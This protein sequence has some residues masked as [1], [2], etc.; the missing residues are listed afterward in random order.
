MYVFNYFDNIYEYAV[1]HIMYY[2]LNNYEINVIAEFAAW[3][4][5]KLL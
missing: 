2:E 5:E 1:L 4:T 3:Q